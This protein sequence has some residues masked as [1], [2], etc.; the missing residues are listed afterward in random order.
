[1]L[2]LIQFLSDE[3]RRVEHDLVMASDFVK[4]PL[5]PGSFDPP[6]QPLRKN[7]A[8]KR[9]FRRCRSAPS[10]DVLSDSPAVRG[11]FQDAK[12][13]LGKQLSLRQ[14]T[15]LLAIY[16]GVGTACF[17]MVKHHI[18]GKKTNGVIDSLYFC[19]VTM[20]TV[21]YGDLVPGSVLAKLLACAFVFSGMAIVA[22]LLSKAADY[23]VEK[24]E[25][26]LVRALHLH[27]K[28]G[29]MKT[30]K[31]METNRMKYRFLTTT[32]LLLLLII[33]GTIFLSKVEKLRLV[34]AF[35]CV[36]ST[37]TT[38]GYGD[39]SFSTLSGRVFAIF[40]ILTSTVCLAQFFLYLAEWNTEHRQQLLAKWVLNRRMTFVDLEAADIDEDG[41]VGINRPL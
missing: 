4:Q 14:V 7:T 13:I 41:S 5:L 16:L 35:Y 10:V 38:L 21:G 1:M 39:Q 6:I 24:Q 12:F 29:E 8:K 37:I 25:I 15:I 22:L 32:V 2:C 20:T 9:R 11:M 26:L 17:F 27:S 19:I 40:W 30:L 34:D 28:A 31:E 23:L 18:K 33:I 36:C 3:I